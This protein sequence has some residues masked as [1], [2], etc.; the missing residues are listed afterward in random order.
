LAPANLVAE[1]E[2][3][4]WKAVNRVIGKNESPAGLLTNWTF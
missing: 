2:K 1:N 3:A 4:A